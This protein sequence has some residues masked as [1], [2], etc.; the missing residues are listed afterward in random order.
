MSRYKEI[1]QGKLYWLTDY[2]MMLPV[3]YYRRFYR[4]VDSFH[5]DLEGRKLTEITQELVPLHRQLLIDGLP[6][7]LLRLIVRLLRLLIVGLLRLLIIRLL[8]LLL[9]GLL[10]IRLLL[11]LLRLLGLLRLL[12]LKIGILIIVVH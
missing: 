4:D 8:R 2:V 9:I 12:V 11:R 3:I 6:V 7:V 1:M 5:D 10:L